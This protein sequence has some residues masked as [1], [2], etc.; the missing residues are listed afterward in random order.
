VSARPDTTWWARA[1]CR[2]IDPDLFF[3]ERG[4][5]AAVAAARTVCQGCPVQ[6]AC[7]DYALA[8]CEDRGIFGGLTGTQRRAL[9]RARRAGQQRGAVA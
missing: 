5:N 2:G 7:L 1:A 9:R 8:I 6:G 3:P 4:D